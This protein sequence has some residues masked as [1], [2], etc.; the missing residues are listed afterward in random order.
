MKAW[1]RLKCRLSRLLLRGRLLEW[2]LGWKMR[3]LERSYAGELLGASTRPPASERLP[4]IKTASPPRRLLFIG[5]VMWESHELIPELERIC[6]VETLDLRPVLQE[7]GAEA[8]PYDFVLSAVRAFIA[9]RSDL[10]PDVILFYARGSLLS[11]E[12]FELLRRRWACPLLGMNLD[13]KVQ[14]LP[15]GLFS[16]GNEGYERWAR[17]VD[18]NLTN[19]RALMDWYADRGLPVYYM[20]EGYHRRFS[21]PPAGVP[22]SYTHELT[23]LGSRRPE[24]EALMKRLWALGLPVKPFGAGWANSSPVERPEA[25]Y[26]AS[27]MNLGIG[28]ASPSLALTTLKARDFECPG[29]G[30]CYVTTWNWELALHYDIGREILC[31]R[32][33]EE[34]VELFSYYRRRPEECL[35]IAQAAWRR[36]LAEHT[37]EKRF[38][39]LFRKLGWVA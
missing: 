2:W 24:R 19:A 18:L 22:D 30:A 16:H 33:D 15:Y 35:R 17:K 4:G 28:F 29:A 21:D 13:E 11:D 14:F 23:F 25:L 26:R 31:Y 6:P 27:L 8:A 20:A 1:H 39:D 34:L 5:D 32:G 36:C 9:A 3:R 12:V 37:W 10:E 38:R 7:G